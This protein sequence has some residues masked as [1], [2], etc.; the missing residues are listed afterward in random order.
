MFQIA[1]GK[2]VILYKKGV[3]SQRKI[4]IYEGEYYAQVGGGF[5]GLRHGGRT[6]EMNTSWKAVDF[7]YDTVEFGRMV[8]KKVDVRKRKRA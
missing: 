2:H 6:T 8:P 5:I 3:Y 1:E 4:Y 7:E